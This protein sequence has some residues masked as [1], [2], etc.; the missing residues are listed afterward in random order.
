MNSDI[1]SAL[2]VV[3]MLLIPSLIVPIIGIS[4]GVVI[5][6]VTNTDVIIIMQDIVFRILIAVIFA[7]IN[8]LLY[9]ELFLKD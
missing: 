1:P 3:A 2:K 5:A 7:A 9:K 6:I 8:V 4:L